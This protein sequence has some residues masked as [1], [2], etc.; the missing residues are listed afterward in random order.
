MSYVEKEGS[1][2]QPRPGDSRVCLPITIDYSGGR[3]DSNKLRIVWVIVLII[4]G[5]IFG[6]GTIFSKNGFFLTN[7]I[8]GLGIMYIVSLIIRF[9]IMKE[10]K[11]RNN[12][13]S[14]IDSDY[15]KSYEDIWGI[16]SI[17]DV[18]PYYCHLRNGKTALYIMFEK[19]VIV[20]QEDDNE[21]AHYDSIAD[22]YNIAGSEDISMCHIDYMGNIGSDSRLNDRFA[23]VST[24]KNPDIKSV[25]IDMY[26]SL[27]E[28]MADK[29]S[30]FDVY[31]FTFRFSER[32][33]WH[34]LEKILA[35]MLEANYVSYKI[36]N[37]DDLRELSKS[38]F[39][40]HEF[41]IVEAGSDAFKT[42]KI[43]TGVT[44]ISIV[45]PDG[46]ERVLNKT[47]DEKREESRLKE[48]EHK[49][50]KEEEKR[51]KLEKKKKK[52]VD[53]EGDSDLIDIF[54]D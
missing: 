50:K 31:V 34:S 54:E 8:F 18:Y 1:F 41:S 45:K 7:I 4:V 27:K 52:V 24:I 23:E 30:T 5:V 40:L 46:T 13:A 16:Y 15:K 37:S 19:D 26:T 44:P 28:D 21:F 10:H 51:R 43:W 33:F 32:A 42:K 14:L 53:D 29:V 25:L 2:M 6:L 36:L 48:E 49:L 9:P 3:S 47:L 35:C 20:G 38:L 12:M 22:A 39:N 11:I 17:D